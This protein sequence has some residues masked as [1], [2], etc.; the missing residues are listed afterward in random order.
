MKE[1]STDISVSYLKD[2]NHKESEIKTHPSNGSL[3]DFFR[4]Q[5]QTVVEQIIDPR[6]V[7]KN[8]GTLGSLLISMGHVSYMLMSR[9]KA[10]SC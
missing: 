1:N 8:S 3:N 6:S 4:V 9:L 10:R 7:L 2:I 5:N